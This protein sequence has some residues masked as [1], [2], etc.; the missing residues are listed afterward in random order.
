MNTWTTSRA[1]YTTYIHTYIYTYIH[2]GTGDFVIVLIMCG[3][4]RL[5]PVS[6]M[7]EPGHSHQHA[8]CIASPASGLA[9]KTS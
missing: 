3:L 2:V 8:R 1:T 9:H 7:L 4:L 6:L 5:A